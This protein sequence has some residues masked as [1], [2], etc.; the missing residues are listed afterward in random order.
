MDEKMI[1]DQICDVCHRMWQL[2][3]I[4]ANDGNI[5]VKLD[6][7]NFLV[8]PAATSKSF[9]TPEMIIKIDKDGN[10]LEGA[11]GYK[12]SSEALMHFRCYEKRDDVGAVVHAHP[13]TATA[14]AVA[15]IHM[16][17]YIM[18]EAVL[19]LGAVPVADYGTPSTSE[20]P[21]S[22]EPYLD[23]HDAIL[24]ENHGALTMG[25]DLLT[26][27]YRMESLELWAKISLNAR[28]LGGA[29]E[30]SRENIDTLLDLRVNRYKMTGRNPGYKKYN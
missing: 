27:Y 8:T 15:H 10:V 20:V 13:P 30:L 1:K 11:E 3:W 19:A 16:D 9:I 29:K 17:D 12:P 25:V 23:E 14:F 4:A 6:D 7:G 26:A 5:T 2:G 22:I 21:D 24:L 18:P 28:L